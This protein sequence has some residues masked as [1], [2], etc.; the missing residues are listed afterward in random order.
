MNERAQQLRKILG[1]GEK[2]FKIC[3]FEWKSVKGLCTPTTND[4]SEKFSPRTDK[5]T[6]EQMNRKQKIGKDLL[7]VYF[8]MLDDPMYFEE[9]NELRNDIEDCNLTLI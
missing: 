1:L 9:K 2:E 4:L 3:Y 7:V 6:S 5:L 8:D